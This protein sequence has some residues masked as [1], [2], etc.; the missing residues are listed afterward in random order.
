MDKK[1][2]IIFSS[3]GILFVASIFIAFNLNKNDNDYLGERMQ[4]N[5]SDKNMPPMKNRTEMNFEDRNQ[6]EIN[7]SDEEINNIKDF[8]ESN[9]NE[10]EINQYCKDYMFKCMYYCVELGG[11]LDFC[12]KSLEAPTR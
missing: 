3:L 10:E 9:P 8:F 11:D 4:N 12:D 1:K 5:K 6:M 7:L 2:I